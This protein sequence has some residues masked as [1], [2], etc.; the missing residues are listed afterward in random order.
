MSSVCDENRRSET[1]LLN[2]VCNHSPECNYSH[3]LTYLVSITHWRRQYR[4]LGLPL[5]DLLICQGVMLP[6]CSCNS[7]NYWK[8]DRV[9]GA[10]IA[11]TSLCDPNKSLSLVRSIKVTSSLMER[12][13]LVS[14]VITTNEINITKTHFSVTKAVW[15][16]VFLP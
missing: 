3:Y 2:H 11:I 16:S 8:T 4:Y 12:I 6:V 14:N 7:G 9:K 15:K 13:V 5:M 10:L 1:S